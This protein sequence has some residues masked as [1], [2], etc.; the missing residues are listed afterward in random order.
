MPDHLADGLA[1]GELP[2][3][4]G[5][6]IRIRDGVEVDVL[7]RLWHRRASL[8]VVAHLEEL[9][10]VDVLVEGRVDV[11]VD[12]NISGQVEL[13]VERAGAVTALDRSWSAELPDVG[14]AGRGPVE[15]LLNA[16]ALVLDEREGEIDLR[17]DT[18]HV[19]ALNVA[20]AALVGDLEIRAD[21]LLRVVV[22]T[23]GDGTS[24]DGAE[25]K[26]SGSDCS[27]VHFDW[28]ERLID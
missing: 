12:R 25:E 15:T 5:D 1:I 6:G 8:R 3:L 24:E 23:L 13:A 11:D 22:I 27:K 10:S 9:G 18:G 2:D 7:E 26:S 21:A 14:G 17:N 16:V 20:D 4:T 19:E 28:Y